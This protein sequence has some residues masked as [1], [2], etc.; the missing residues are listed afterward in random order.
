MLPEVEHDVSVPTEAEM[1]DLTLSPTR[2]LQSLIPLDSSSV[3]RTV[4]PPPVL[5]LRPMNKD[6]MYGALFGM[7]CLITMILVV[8]SPTYSQPRPDGVP[9]IGAMV[10]VGTI[11]GL[12]W[13]AFF[14]AAPKDLYIRVSTTLSFAG[15]AP[16]ALVLLVSPT[17]TG[18]FVSLGV[19]ALAFSDFIWT[20]KNKLGF[21]FVA[22][23]FELVAEMLQASP[24]VIAVSGVI[25]LVSSMWSY[26]CCQLLSN[27]GEDDGWSIGLLW[28]LF[29]FYW[30][31]HFFKTLISVVVSGTVMYW[32]H[33]WGDDQPESPTVPMVL[34]SPRSSLRTA[35]IEMEPKTNNAPSA[36][37]IVLHY[38]RVAMTSVFGSVCLG[39]LC[40][41]IAHF[42][43]T[44][45]RMAKRDGSYRWLR[46]V[47]L[48]LA[49]RIDAFTQLYHKYTLSYVAA[50]SQSF[51]VAAA[52]VWSLFEECG[53]EAMVD[54]DLTSRLLLFA[55]NSGA[56]CM[57]TLASLV[58]FGSHLQVYGTVL[59]FVVGYSVSSTATAMLNT[60]V[61][62]LFVC[63]AQN[64]DR[65][66]QL[67]PIIYHRYV[68]LSELK[69]FKE[70]R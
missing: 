17:W 65:L 50:Y 36:N 61:K 48:P 35:S 46:G 9:Y 8:A 14:F 34:T 27:V 41:P 33:H 11:Y 68:R 51:Y 4:K 6:V 58:L 1:E 19:L 23:V 52:E 45:L 57:G 64:P 26:W 21:D 25:L 63:F 60:A 40:S 37:T 24:A 70:R 32:Y 67:N 29:H 28:L 18:F 42:F 38:T 16:M 22:V 54:D 10:I 39:A 7:Q 47:V 20:R 5:T 2:D 66:S 69:N 13:V 15:M 30:T 44:V 31:S 12:I 49:P 55:A 53:I 56:G 43:W 3:K 59:S 62:T